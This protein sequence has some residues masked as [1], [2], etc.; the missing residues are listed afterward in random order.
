[1]NSNNDFEQWFKREIAEQVLPDDQFSSAIIARLSQKAQLTA[2]INRWCF[3]A[4]CLVLVAIGAVAIIQILY[5]F[6][7]TY[8]L[9]PND[10]SATSAAVIGLSCVVWFFTHLMEALD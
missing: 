3:L 7:G 10:L 8:P 6:T 4:I 5:P 2:S 9:F 1:M